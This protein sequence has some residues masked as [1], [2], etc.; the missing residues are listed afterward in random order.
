M[1]PRRTSPL[2]TGRQRHREGRTKQ[3]ERRTP[4][5][6]H[7]PDADGSH[8]GAAG[9]RVLLVD[10][11][12]ED[13]L[14]RVL[15]RDG[16]EVLTADAQARAIRLLSVFDP[17]VIVF[18]G[19]SC[20]ELRLAA[21]NAGIIALVQGQS[22]AERLTALEAGAD[23]CVASPWSDIELRARVLAMGR[24]CAPHSAGGR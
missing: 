12:S 15:S 1:L 21:P 7:I 20:R 8:P 14:A 10:G 13:N 9:L 4:E 5:D 23:D 6:A 17:E 18:V 3:E 22:V 11:R 19:D 24:R 2:G 16:H